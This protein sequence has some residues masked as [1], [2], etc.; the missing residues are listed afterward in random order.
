MTEKSNTVKMTTTQMRTHMNDDD[1][2]IIINKDGTFVGILTPEKLVDFDE[3]PTRVGD[4]LHYLYGDIFN[5]THD[6]KI[7]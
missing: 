2:A 3:L 5:I 6:R 7:Q 1:Y 4:I